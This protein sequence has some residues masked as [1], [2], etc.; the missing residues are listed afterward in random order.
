M[1]MKERVYWCTTWG[2]VLSYCGLI[3]FISSQS[4]SVPQTVPSADI[5]AHGVLYAGLGWLWARAV[6]HS[7]PTTRARMNLVSALVF[8]TLYGLSDEW[9]QLY[10]PE[11]MAD[12]RDVIADAVGG[13]VGGLGFLVWRVRMALRPKSVR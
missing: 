6:Q 10:V 3:F 1:P 5:G 7:W 2:A 12:I 4:F 13:T 9:H 11:R 8:T